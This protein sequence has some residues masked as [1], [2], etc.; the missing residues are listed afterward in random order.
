MY[1]CSECGDCSESKRSRNSQ[2]DDDDMDAI[3]NTALGDNTSIPIITIQDE[4]SNGASSMDIASADSP[5]PEDDNAL[6][7]SIIP[8]TPIPTIP[9]VPIIPTTSKN[10]SLRVTSTLVCNS[11]STLKRLAAGEFANV[12]LLT[13]RVL[14]KPVKA[15][16]KL[17]DPSHRSSI[18][19]YYLEKQMFEKI[20]IHPNIIKPLEEHPLM[21]VYE[22]QP[23]SFWFEALDGDLIDINCN[24]HPRTTLSHVHFVLECILQTALALNHMHSKGIAHLDVKPE[25]VLVKITENGSPMCKLCDF[26]G[27]T[28][29]SADGKCVANITTNTY[30]PPEKFAGRLSTPLVDGKKFDIYSLGVSM[31]CLLTKEIV[32]E[33]PESTKSTEWQKSTTSG[34]VHT[35]LEEALK[36]ESVSVKSR[37]FELARKTTSK[38]TTTRPSIESVI[39]ELSG[40]IRMLPTLKL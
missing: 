10:T 17:Y 28:E 32:F 9:T 21:G 34:H 16:V 4:H 37:I 36:E 33:H 38:D 14:G 24:T 13:D 31:I 25:N 15:V 8:I 26:S 39:L 6:N 22:N 12:Y 27:S 3:T 7:A 18:E 2:D 5:S 30:A 40:I 19:Q 11:K 35:R 29:M 23:Y 1:D 20:G